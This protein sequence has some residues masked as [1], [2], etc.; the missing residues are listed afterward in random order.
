MWDST[1]KNETK[2]SKTI[3]TYQA[4]Q[5]G[6]QYLFIEADDADAI[7][8]SQEKKEIVSGTSSML[9]NLSR[10]FSGMQKAGYSSIMPLISSGWAAPAMADTI[11]PWL[12]PMRK[13]LSVS[14]L[15]KD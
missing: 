7:T 3:L 9:G 12:V 8:V 13:M 14:T 6:K 11:P 15:S 5:T 1:L 4:Q 2:K 10:A